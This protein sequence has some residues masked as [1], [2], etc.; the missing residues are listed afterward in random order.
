MCLSGIPLAFMDREI[1]LGGFRWCG[2]VAR[3]SCVR[4][5]V[6]RGPNRCVQPCQ[7]LVALKRRN[8]ESVS[9]SGSASTDANAPDSVLA[10]NSEL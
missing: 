1:E 9:S 3:N 10:R 4:A 2:V 7:R 8:M 6:D 5:A